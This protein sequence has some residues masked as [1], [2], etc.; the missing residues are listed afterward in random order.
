MHIVPRDLVMIAEREGEAVGLIVM[1]PNSNTLIRDLNGRPL[2]V[3][4]LKLLW[5]LTV[6]FPR[7]PTRSAELEP[8]IT[9]LQ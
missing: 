1:V 3:G 4:W 6:R 5:R 2:P 9:W 7:T 8:H